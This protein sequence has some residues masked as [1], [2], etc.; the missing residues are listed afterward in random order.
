MIAI[1]PAR[2]GSKGLRGKNIK[3]LY[4]KPLIAYTIE[5]ALK[6]K[7]ITRVI[8]DSDDES[9][10]EVSKKYGAETPYIRPGY[11]AT[12]KAKSIDVM[13]HA[14]EKLQIMTDFI[15]L[16]P[17][18]PLR[19]NVHIDESISLFKRKKADSVISFCKENHPIYWHKE[20]DSEGKIKKI[21]DDNYITNRQELMS[22][23]F[24]NGAIYILKKELVFKGN[25]Y[26]D[27]TYA[28]IMDDK[29]SIDIDTQEDFDYCRLIMN[30]YNE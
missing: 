10:I 12:D 13:K 24:P 11:L 7:H 15:L 20:I 23:Y 18:S 26:T 29:S 21:F 14:I 22:S 27:N 5:A 30:T 8:V 3:P 16:Q 6:S 25:Y 2:G 9:I 17:T 19:T 1:I 4:G 28:Y